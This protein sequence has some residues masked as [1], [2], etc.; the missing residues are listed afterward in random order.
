MPALGC[1]RRI[2]GGAIQIPHQELLKWRPVT[3]LLTQ[4]PVS[5]TYATSLAQLT[6]RQPGDA[7]GRGECSEGG[8][9]LPSPG[10]SGKTPGRH[11]DRSARSSL[12]W[13]RGRAGNTRRSRVP[14]SAYLELSCGVRSPQQEPWWN[15]DRRARCA[16]SA[17]RAVTGAEVGNTFVG[18]LPPFSSFV[19]VIASQ[20]VRPEVAGPM[21]GSA[22][23]SS[24]ASRFWIASSLTLLAMTIFVRRWQSSG[25]DASRE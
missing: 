3:F 8:S 5:D 16:F 25:A 24:P 7:G 4:V 21:T 23:Q 12:D 11:H 10:G 19:F 20:R 22:K 9:S 14:G 6:G 2:G 18:V 1:I 17:R 13:D 15:A